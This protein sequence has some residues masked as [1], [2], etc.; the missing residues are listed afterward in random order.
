[1]ARVLKRRT[2]VR[3]PQCGTVVNACLH[4]DFAKRATGDRQPY[5]LHSCPPLLGRQLLSPREVKRLGL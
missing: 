5:T 4:R 3:R 1:M 2:L